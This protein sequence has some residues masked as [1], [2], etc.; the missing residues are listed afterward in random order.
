[1][2]KPLLNIQ[3]LRTSFF[4]REGELKAV[5][6]VNFTINPGEILGLVGESGCGKSVTALSVLR[7]IPDPPGQIISGKIFFKG[8]DLLEKT[9]EEMRA[10]RG[11]QI[12]MIFQDPTSSLNPVFKIGVQV[13]EV[14]EIH[15]SHI[16]S[17]KEIFA[18]TV[19]MLHLVGIPQAEGRR[20]EFPHEFSGGMQQRVMTA[21]ALACQGDLLIADEPTTS[22]DVTIQAQ[23]I[24][25]M[26]KLRDELGL[27]ILL[28]T[29][30]MGLIAEMCDRV[31][32]M[33]LGSIVETAQILDLFDNPQH[34]Y[35]QALLACLPRLDRDLDHLDTIQGRVISPIDLPEACK[36]AP[37][38]PQVMDICRKA[39]PTE[40][41][42]APN[43]T[44][45][46]F[47]YSK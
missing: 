3:N 37:R 25:L 6:G 33:Y 5:D 46:C 26:L 23:I 13:D 14:L 34:P 17:E 24:D 10:I 2:T 22:L 31:A 27:A 19:E 1:M 29:H 28:I 7:L 39:I 20:M 18:R 38:C 11:D 4:L 21:M 44:V 15:R 32:V 16:F 45:S 43:H 9:K 35:T 36:F 30:N 40:A 42:V 41:Q 47:L 12:S 8:E